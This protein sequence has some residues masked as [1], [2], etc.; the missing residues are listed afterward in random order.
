MLLETI[1]KSFLLFN[2]P[3]YVLYYNNFLRVEGRYTRCVLMPIFCISG[4]WIPLYCGW[5][6]KC[7]PFSIYCKLWRAIAE[8]VKPLYCDE[9]YE[10]LMRGEL[11]ELAYFYP[12]EPR[13]PPS[14][15]SRSDEQITMKSLSLKNALRRDLGFNPGI[16]CNSVAEV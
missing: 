9:V 4:S 3:S 2:K 12:K 13:E 15:T 1:N 8:W 11:S 5:R 16:S 6:W 10:W 14:F 7:D